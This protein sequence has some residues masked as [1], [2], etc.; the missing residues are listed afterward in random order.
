MLKVF[1]CILVL[2]GLSG[3]V[4]TKESAHPI[5]QKPGVAL[6]PKVPSV[7]ETIPGVDRKGVYHKVQKGETIWRIAKTYNVSIAD[8][9][10]SNKIPNVAQI[11]VNQLVF[12]P[13]VET[14]QDVVS[15][16]EESPYEFGWPLKG[17]IIKYFHQPDGSQ[18]TKGIAIESQD[19]ESVRAS[20]R[21]KVVFS[22]YLPGYGETIVLDHGD[23]FHSVYGQNGNLNVKLNDSVEKNAVIAQVGKTNNRSCLYF[24]IRKNSIED[25]PLYYLPQ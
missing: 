13:G 22:D 10:D 2:W 14:L 23:G 9:I 6:E 8:I 17:K 16:E 20:R 1:F 25:N 3:C 21:G 24:E 15:L 18:L 12:I 11:E 19:G 5:D 4:A 7:S